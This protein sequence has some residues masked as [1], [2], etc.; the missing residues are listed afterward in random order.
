ML[1]ALLVTD[2]ADHQGMKATRDALHLSRI[3][4]SHEKL[5]AG[6]PHSKQTNKTKI[7]HLVPETWETQISWH[8]Q[9]SCENEKH[10]SMNE[11]GKSAVVNV[12]KRQMARMILMH[13][14]SF[15][16]LPLLIMLS[17]IQ[18]SPA[19]YNLTVSFTYS[20]SSIAVGQIAVDSIPISVLIPRHDFNSFCSTSSTYVVEQSTLILSQ[21]LTA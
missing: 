16:C 13:N 17:V 18:V 12:F 20:A 15:L 2:D 7:A 1:P 6:S 9:E 3:L 4:Q 5:F 14:G 8:H 10:V 11:K 21:L 19:A